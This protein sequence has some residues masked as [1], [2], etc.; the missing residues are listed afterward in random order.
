MS[1]ASRE[2]FLRRWRRKNQ[3]KI[4]VRHPAVKPMYLIGFG[5]LVAKRVTAFKMPRHMV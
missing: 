1:T 3:V 4:K 5:Q 2:M